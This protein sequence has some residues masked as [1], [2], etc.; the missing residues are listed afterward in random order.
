MGFFP[1][2]YTITCKIEKENSLC[3]A[4]DIRTYMYCISD[5]F[6]VTE[7]NA[8]C[9]CSGCVPVD[10]QTCCHPGLYR[11]IPTQAPGH[12]WNQQ[13]SGLLVQ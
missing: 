9:N 10:E 1:F 4:S 6:P 8:D 7:R 3:I 2:K 5:C 11:G 13:L 12:S